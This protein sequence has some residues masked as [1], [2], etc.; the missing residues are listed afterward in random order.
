[1]LFIGVSCLLAARI[2]VLP[3]DPTL[4]YHLLKLALDKHTHTPLTTFKTTSTR[5]QTQTSLV[6]NTVIVLRCA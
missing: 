4:L 5:K 6:Q 1:M 3:C 2:V